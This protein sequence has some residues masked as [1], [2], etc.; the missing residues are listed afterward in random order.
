L[1]WI[2]G[3]LMVFS[4]LKLVRIKGCSCKLHPAAAENPFYT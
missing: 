1:K 2:I 4:N 3:D